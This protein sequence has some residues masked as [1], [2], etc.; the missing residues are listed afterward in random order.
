MKHV[1]SISLGSST[2]DFE[3]EIE[4]GGT[5]VRLVREGV[6]GDMER[7]K[8]RIREVDGKVDAIGLGGIDVY[9]YVA[10]KQFVVGDGMR[11]VEEAKSTP[12]VD[13]SG[14]KDT[15][16]REAVQDLVQRGLVTAETNVLMVSAM[17][18]FGM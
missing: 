15:L 16:E 12:V 4:M 17:D 3:R 7:A 18:R 6:D 9:L 13:G 2:G 1:I 14:L 10:G 11:L 8:R 5:Q